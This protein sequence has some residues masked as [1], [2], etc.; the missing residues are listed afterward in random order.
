MYLVIISPSPFIYASSFN[1]SRWAY[2][3]SPH[4]RT[5]RNK[6][7]YLS[8]VANSPAHVCSTVNTVARFTKSLSSVEP[9]IPLSLTVMIS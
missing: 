8:V 7:L 5:F 4:A 2:F 3:F 1:I 6:E 9:Y